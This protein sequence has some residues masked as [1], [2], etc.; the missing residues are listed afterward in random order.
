[1]VSVAMSEEAGQLGLSKES[2]RTDLQ[3]KLRQNGISVME[4][5]NENLADCT[6]GVTITVVAPA[7]GGS[8]SGSLSLFVSEAVGLARDPSILVPARTGEVG[9]AL[10][11]SSGRSIRD[12][13][14][15]LVNQFLNAWLSVNPKSR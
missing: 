10:D 11:G 9:G 7:Q 14:G 15:D 13:V 12:T 4:G 8:P 1:M 5:E 2:L 3:L 6:L